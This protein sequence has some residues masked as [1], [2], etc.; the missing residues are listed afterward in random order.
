MSIAG[1]GSTNDQ[2]EKLTDSTSKEHYR[3]TVK[4]FGI[5]V[6]TSTKVHSV[7]SSVKEDK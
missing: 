5:P 3:H 1:F 6:F 4:F 2:K 7:D